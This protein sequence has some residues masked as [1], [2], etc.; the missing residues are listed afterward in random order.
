MKD[1]AQK[2]VNCLQLKGA[3]YGDVR[4]VDTLVETIATRNGTAEELRVRESL[5]FGV[6]AIVNGAWGFAS[7]SR[8]EPDEIEAVV[9]RAVAIAEASSSVPGD[10]VVLSELEPVQASYATPVE[11]DPFAVSLDDKL[12]MLYRADEGMR[13]VK[14]VSLAQA[15]MTCYRVD[16]VLASS[17]GALID[18]RIVHSGAGMAATAVEGG[19]MQVRS[20]PNSFRGNFAAA[21]YEYIEALRLVDHAERV[22]EDVVALMKAPQCPDTTTTLILEGGQLAL[23]VHESIGHPI[24]LDRVFGTE[25]SYAGTSFLTLDKLDSLQYGSEIVNVVGDSTTPGGLGTY[26]YDDEGVPA[27]CDDIIRNGKFVGYLSSRETAPRIGRKS[28]GAMRADGWQRIPLIRMPNVNLLPGE[29]SLDELIASTDDGIFML[30]NRSWSIDD[31]RLNFQFGTEIA[32]QISNGKLGQM[33]KNPTYTGITP[34]FWNSC[35]AICGP[36]EWKFWG[37]PNCGKGQP[38]QCAHVGHAVAPARFRNVRVGVLQ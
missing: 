32:Y 31:K 17:E 11:K 2:V 10:P 30:T 6:R 33:Y 25:A 13:Q 35:D 16:Q 38:G 9:S 24:E 5:G 7:S 22:G 21:G 29:G 15:F 4:I 19:E 1:F 3:S 28:T 27:R 12:D 36:E 20:Y 34:E 23:Q 14:G 8:V 37:T 18:Q 26:G